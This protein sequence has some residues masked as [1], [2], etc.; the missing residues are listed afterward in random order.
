LLAAGSIVF[1]IGV[2]PLVKPLIELVVTKEF[3]LLLFPGFNTAFFLSMAALA[4]GAALFAVRSTWLAWPWPARPRAS[5]IYDGIVKF[6]EDVADI[7]LITQNGKLRHY[8]TIILGVVGVIMPFAGFDYIR[9]ADVQFVFSG[10]EDIFKTALL[11]LSVIGALASVFFR[12]HLAAALSLGVMGYAIGG[13]FLLEPAPDVALVQFLVETLATV[14]VIVMLARLG[15]KQR[16]A[17]MDKL[18][19]QRQG[20]ILLSAFIAIALGVGVTLFAVSAV[21]TRP[22]RETIAQWHLDNAYEEVGVKDVVASIVT[23]FRGTDTLIEITVFAIAGLGVLTLL[24]LTN[25][26]REDVARVEQR[27]PVINTPLSR[28]VATLVLPFA[29]LVSLYHLLYAGDGPGDGFTAGV[30]SGLAVALWYVVFGYSETKRRLRWL[31]PVTMIR[32]G[33]TLA[34][35]NATLPL[36]LDEAFF[37]VIKVKGFTP[38]AD[39]HLA[40]TLLFEIGIFLT[41]LGSVSVI[42]EAIAHPTEVEQI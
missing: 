31:Q 29:V 23:D 20:G 36:L 34:L 35:V 21:S 38:P 7:L 18:W 13:I 25:V 26:A 8:L 12:Q 19:Q 3:K 39:L 2:V 17:V 28:F 27:S 4:G 10:S 11:A 6:A 15:L 5:A 37:H 32:I 22:E 30:V 33:L 42:M 1:G 41:V 24:S 16:Q 14:L 40:S 9:Q